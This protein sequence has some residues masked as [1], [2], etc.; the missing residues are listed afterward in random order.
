M[1][2]TQIG[3]ARVEITTCAVSGGRPCRVVATQGNTGTRARQA[4][5]TIG[6]P[7]G[8]GRDDPGYCQVQR[9][10]LRRDVFDE[11]PQII[12][13]DRGILSGEGLLPGPCPL[14]D[15][16]APGSSPP[17]PV[18]RAAPAAPAA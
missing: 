3:N 13:G 7:G 18:G 15:S 4:K 1:A 11:P 6:P 16:S 17:L 12:V 8:I 10:D 14:L 2:N 5:N 9:D